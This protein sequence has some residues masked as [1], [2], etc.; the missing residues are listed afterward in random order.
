MK[1]QIIK[2]IERKKQVIK[3][4]IK[5]LDRLVKL[6]KDKGDY[7]E[8]YKLLCEEEK[9]IYYQ[10]ALFDIEALINKIEGDN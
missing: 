5:E 10:T 9:Q 6:A 7:L 2:E 4:E 3:Q 8:A 1:E